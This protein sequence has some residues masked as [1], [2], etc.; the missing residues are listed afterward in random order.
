MQRIWHQSLCSRMHDQIHILH[1]YC[2]KKRFI[3]YDQSPYKAKAVLK[4]NAYWPDIR[5][6]MRT[7][8]CD[9]HRPFVQFL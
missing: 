3:T 6:L 2:A 7:A 4:I 8:I 9:R 1:R 5:H